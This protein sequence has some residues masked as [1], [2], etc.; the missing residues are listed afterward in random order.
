[1]NN[2]KTQ[3][4]SARA[5]NSRGQDLSPSLDTSKLVLPSYDNAEETAF[6]V[7][8]CHCQACKTKQ[9]LIE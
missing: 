6:K 1:M 2:S 3:D 7:K 9:R 8:S 4:R 5:I